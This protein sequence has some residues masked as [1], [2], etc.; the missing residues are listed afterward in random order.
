MSQADPNV[1]R[2]EVRE[3]L[4]QAPK[5]PH[6]MYQDWLELL[7]VHYTLEPQ[8]VQA[9]LPAGLTVDTYPDHSG[10]ARAWIGAVPFHMRGVRPRFTPSVP[11]LSAFLETNLRTYVHREGQGPAVYFF[12]LDAASRIACAVA[13]KTFN[14]PYHFAQMHAQR[15]GEQFNYSTVRYSDDASLRTR[16]EVGGPLGVSEPGS[17]AYFLAERYLLVTA[18]RSGKLLWGRVH[19]SPYELREANLLEYSQTLSQAAGLPEPPSRAEH[20]CYCEGVS[21]RVWAL[22]SEP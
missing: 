20:V 15:E 18:L 13:R 21:T 22:K 4:R 12:S 5:G 3:A 8:E 10:Q 6:V 9:L 19:H 11:G 7:F 16:F 14:L 17:L 1:P 2:I